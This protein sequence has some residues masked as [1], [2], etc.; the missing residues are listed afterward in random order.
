MSGAQRQKYTLGFIRSD[1]NHVLLLNRQ[2][3]PWMGR[4]NGVGGKLDAG[5]SPYECIVRETMEETGLMLPQYEDRGVMRWV[6]DG[7]ECG[8][9]HVFTAEVLEE[10]MQQYPTPRRHCHEGILDW[11]A[12]EW[13]LHEDNSGVVDNVQRMLVDLFGAG[14]H[15]RWVSRYEGLQLVSCTYNGAGRRGEV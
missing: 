1:T 6:R 14:P 5:E 15:A 9:V 12:M 13:V 2:K 7:K 11:K 4:W 8:G 10:E 3:A